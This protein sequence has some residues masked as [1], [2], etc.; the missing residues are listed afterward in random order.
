M[1]RKL[2]LSAERRLELMRARMH[3]RGILDY[4]LIGRYCGIL[5][6][7]FVLYVCI[8][9]MEGYSE[10]RIQK[11]LKNTPNQNLEIPP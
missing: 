7:P 10:A 3:I 4:E 9:K 2:Q 6:F 1:L 11:Y 5:F 8:G